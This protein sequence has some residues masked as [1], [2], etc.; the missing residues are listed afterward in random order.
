ME[1]PKVSA[2]KLVRPREEA[3][4]F[5][6][7]Q[8]K[9]GAEIKAMRI[10]NGT[11]LDNARAQK[12]EWTTVTTELLKELFDSAAVADDSNDWVGKIYPEYAEFGNFV[13]QFYAEMDHR[14]KKL[15][16]IIKQIQKVPSEARASVPAV[17][18]A[19]APSAAPATPASAAALATAPAVAPAVTV[20]KPQ[21]V[22]PETVRG[23]LLVF[24]GEESSRAAVAEFLES[25]DVELTVVDQATCAN[26]AGITEALDQARGT[27][28]AVIFAGD[29]SQ[30]RE[31]E[32]GFCVGRLGL[33]RICV[34]HSQ[35]ET[36]QPDAR[37]LTHV[38][39]DST[40]G[41]Q[42]VLARHLKRA[43]LGVDLNR[44]C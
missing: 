31:F 27:S 21:P 36:L 15:K 39:L 30:N 29:P 2:A 20:P 7:N 24:G 35:N 11:E 37:G 23:M 26:P 1:P 3:I 8:V 43:G 16:A 5:I 4:S 19:P 44:L 18:T 14:L 33:R 13:E 10:R 34:V 22:A 9:R 38:Q 41:W 25:L 28:F 12:L 42:L 32:L 6:Q 40:G 17:A